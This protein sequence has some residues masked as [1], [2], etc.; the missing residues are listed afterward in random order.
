MDSRTLP[1]LQLTKQ[2]KLSP[3]DLQSL[4][5]ATLMALVPLQTMSLV[6]LQMEL[7]VTHQSKSLPQTQ[8]VETPL[9]LEVLFQLRTLHQLLHQPTLLEVQLL[10]LHLSQVTNHHHQQPLPQ[11]HQPA[12]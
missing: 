9:L 8:L 4:C 12:T 11:H 7:L 2:F 5:Q 1:K 3:L 10:S 6:L